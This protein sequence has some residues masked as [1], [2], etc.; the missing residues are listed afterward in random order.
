MGRLSRKT[1]IDRISK[2][3][4]KL[5]WDLD[6]LIKEEY[7][8]NAFIFISDDGTLS[9]CDSSK[10]TGRSVADEIITTD[11]TRHPFSIGAW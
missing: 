9:I 2:K 6:R 1:R 3:I 11:D 8:Q 5:G 7:G 10:A 4:I